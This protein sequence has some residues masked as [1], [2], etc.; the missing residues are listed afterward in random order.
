MLR[1]ENYLF[2]L[3]GT[4]TDP[5]LGI[6]NSIRHALKKFGLPS[7]DEGTLNMFVG[8]PL[9]DSFR[10]YCGVSEEESLTLLAYYRE[11]FTEKG[12]F[13]NILY[14][15]VPELLAEL[16]REGAHLYLATSKPEEFA[17]K[18]LSHFDLLEYFD[19]VGGSTLD[20]Q[21]TDKGDVIAYV[22]EQ[23]GIDPAKTVMIGDRTYDICGG[24]RS[25][26]D[27]VGVLFGYG[28]R[29]ELA[30]ATYLI[31]DPADLLRL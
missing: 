7:L 4:L 15:S 8:P 5:G 22:L 3:D 2:D 16:R 26:L 24:K 9:L 23:T 30:D 17:K 6:K 13:E 28:D 21:R 29:E 14:D 27:T 11:Y 12:I 1:Y 31:T 18:I 20:E 19:F 25:G 10:R